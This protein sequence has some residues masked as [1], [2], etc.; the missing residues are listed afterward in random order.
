[1]MNLRCWLDYIM[2]FQRDSYIWFCR[3]Q[4]LFE[5]SVGTKIN[6]NLKF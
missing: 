1:M 2:F 6:Y 5:E 3:P 4:I